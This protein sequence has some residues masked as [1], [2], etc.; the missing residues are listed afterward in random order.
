VSMRDISLLILCAA[1]A[2]VLG[3]AG[4]DDGDTPEPEPKVCEPARSVC[5]GNTVCGPTGCEPAYDRRYEVSVAGAWMYDKSF[6]RC[7]DDPD[8]RL[9]DAATVTVYSSDSDDPIIAGGSSQAQ[10]L[11]SD[12][13]Y[14]V[15]DLGEESCMVELTAERLRSGRA[16][17]GDRARSALLTLRAMPL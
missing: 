1:M 13:S 6:E 4:A 2:F 3:C 8:C 10:I 17:C 15:V 7:L 11:V 16:S 5:T 12:G 9:I 14:L